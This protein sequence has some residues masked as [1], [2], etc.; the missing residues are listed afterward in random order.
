M[1]TVANDHF[2]VE[3]QNL[4]IGFQYYGVQ[5]ANSKRD[6]FAEA[7]I[8]EPYRPPYKKGLGMPSSTIIKTPFQSVSSGASVARI[9]L[10]P[11]KRVLFFESGSGT[12]VSGVG[13]PMDG[14]NNSAFFL[15]G[16]K[17]Q[18]ITL[19][20]NHRE[21]T[22][23]ANELAQFA[24]G[25]NLADDICNCTFKVAELNQ[26]E[27]TKTVRQFFVCNITFHFGLPCSLHFA[28]QRG[29]T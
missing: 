6:G 9:S 3:R 2:Q 23:A 19:E 7:R 15:P 24:M 14:A 16:A 17:F 4:T 10:N 27:S 13:A 26:E 5:C 20:H 8:Q 29:I 18:E 12:P 1:G 11:S 22:F 25:N 28:K 21:H